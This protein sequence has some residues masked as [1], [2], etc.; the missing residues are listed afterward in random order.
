M[1]L[2]LHLSDLHQ[3][4]PS[5]WQFDYSDKFGLEGATGD[6]KIDHLRRT[7]RAL[8]DVLRTADRVLD[9]IVVSGDLTNANRQDGY[10][11]F[12]PLL[13]ELG[14]RKP[15]ADHIVVVPGNHDADWSIQPGNSAKFTRFI[16][17]VR[18]SYRS[19]LIYGVDYDDA[20]LARATGN[21]RRAQPILELDDVAIL[22]LSSADFC[23]VE[24]QKTETPWDEL[25]RSFRASDG[26]EEAKQARAKAQRELLE[27]RVQDMARIHKHQLDALAERM[28]S[29]SLAVGADEDVRLRIA[30]L[31]HP[32]GPMTDRE[33]IKAFDALTNLEQVRTFLYHQGFHIVLHG[34]KHGSYLAWDWLLPPGTDLNAIPRR[35]LVVGSP[36]DF[37]PDQTVCRLLDVCPDS[38]HP[39]AGAPRLRIIDVP[40]VRA[41]QAL[42]LDFRR[43]CLSL[44]Q[45][46]VRSVD[47]ESPWVVQARTA[48]AAYQQLRD[49]PT[50]KELPRPVISVVEDPTTAGRLPL[51]YPGARDDRW[52]ENLVAWWQ[53]PR[54]E[55]V[56]AVAG[57]DFNH[58]QRLYGAKH[59]IEKA[60]RALP[61]SKAIALLVDSDEAGNADVEFPAF[62][63]VQLQA[64]R[65]SKDGTLLDA[66]GIYR[67]QDLALWWPVNMAELA[68]IQEMALVAAA[69]NESLA[70]PIRAGRLIAM[71]SFGIHDTV[72]PQMAGT[73]LDRAVD[74]KPQ[75]PHRLAYLAA[76]P[77]PET[78]AEWTEALADIGS[79]EG[80]VVLVPSIGLERLR[81]A[82]EMHHE[83]GDTGRGFVRIVRTVDKLA[84]DASMAADALVGDPKAKTLEVWA[85]QLRSDVSQVLRA[86]RSV[87]RA[88]DIRWV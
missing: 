62:T 11:A 82:L 7:L 28:K 86:L 66:V 87:V 23:G 59:A 31:H 35:T 69:K 73:V 20:T 39:V 85:N 55:A 13:Q 2:I 14:D 52:L 29:S 42:K 49:L 32:I 36:G 40:G 8:G 12:E 88:K 74:L 18:R 43:P 26:S 5:D 57:S 38:D 61:S 24:E 54:P 81:E 17:S 71:A 33:E 21:R 30:V 4:S 78:Q 72:F 70:K 67:K 80:D 51:N 76:Q 25:I 46:F 1:S 56:H 63:A 41:S 27:L 79:H 60:A 3:G 65:D 48:D 6:T 53:H 83:L 64:R 37:R 15:D 47:L 22:A 50:D 9:V 19:P 58:G 45:P 44:A 10:D 16:N 34:H 77:R 84:E 68:Y 75:W